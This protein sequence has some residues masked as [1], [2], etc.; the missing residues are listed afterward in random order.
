MLF[1]PM[2]LGA[3]TCKFEPADHRTDS[4]K[5]KDLGSHDAPGGQLSGI[6]VANA[7]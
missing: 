1:V 7:L 5:T 4:E 2:A 6:D 3:V